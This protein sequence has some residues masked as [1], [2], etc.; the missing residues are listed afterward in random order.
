MSEFLSQHGS[1]LSSVRKP[2]LDHIPKIIEIRQKVKSVRRRQIN[3]NQ[4]IDVPHVA[5]ASREGEL[6]PAN[7]SIERASQLKNEQIIVFKNVIQ[8]LSITFSHSTKSQQSF[9]FMKIILTMTLRYLLNKTSM[10]YRYS[11]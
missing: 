11:A 3:I 7:Q 4:D 2:L 5:L 6:F 8:K 1:D 10:V 9:H